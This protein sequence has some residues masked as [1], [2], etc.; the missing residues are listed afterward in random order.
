MKNIG[1]SGY[2]SYELCHPLPV[3]N[4]K[5]VGIEYA[6]SCARNACKMMKD[7]IAG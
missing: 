5:K 3:K 7:L 2:F 6:E 4:G 1:Y